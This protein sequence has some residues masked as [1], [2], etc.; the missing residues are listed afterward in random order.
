MPYVYT[1]AFRAHQ[2]G[3]LLVHPLY[4]DY[5]ALSGAY[6]ATD[7][8]LFGDSL[9]VAPITAPVDSATGLASR[10]IF[11][12]PGVWFDW[13]RASLLSISEPSGEWIDRSYGLSEVPIFARPGHTVPMQTMNS[14]KSPW[15]D[16]LLLYVIPLAPGQGATSSSVY[17]DSGDGQGYKEGAYSVTRVTQERLA[18]GSVTLKIDPKTEGQGFPTRPTHRTYEVIFRATELKGLPPGAVKC[19]GQ[20]L[21]QLNGTAEATASGVNIAKEDGNRGVLRMWLRL[22]RQPVDESV[23]LH[24][25]HGSATNS[26]AKH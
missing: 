7:E 18:D 9:L 22:P 25:A 13:V 17:D 1:A 19:N 16:P 15:A 8:Y 2:T 10:R 5:P 26:Y 3:V 12:P 11:M 21:P 24:L 20:E 4:Y 23:T 6:Q 14:T